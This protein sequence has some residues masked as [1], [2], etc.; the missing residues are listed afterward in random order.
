[1]NNHNKN[2]NRYL[3]A[4]C[5]LCVGLGLVLFDV[6][7]SAK[8]GNTKVK[9]DTNRIE[10]LWRQCD[11][12]QEEW[13]DYY[14]FTNAQ[15][16]HYNLSWENLAAF[17]VK[18]YA[19]DA[20]MEDEQWELKQIY[21]YRDDMYQAYT[22][23]D[24]GSELYILFRDSTSGMSPDYIVMADVRK[25]PGEAAVLQ[26]KKWSYNSMLEW[27]SYKKWF[28]GDSKMADRIQVD[29]KGEIYDSI[30]GSGSYYAIYDYLDR[31]GGNKDISWEI[32]E[33]TSYVGRN[34]EIASI[35]CAVGTEKINLLVDV[36]NRRY[37]VVK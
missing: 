17:A 18:D 37:A 6:N 34:G 13:P 30:Y 21:H 35:S 14:F 8:G 16:R 4:F 3:I 23:S 7:T 2:R 27:Y 11:L 33:N 32:D 29:I 22:E 36:W 19:M 12:P 15:Q 10:D 31:F 26:E 5:I 24:K 1:M 28:D 25:T 20:E 9:T